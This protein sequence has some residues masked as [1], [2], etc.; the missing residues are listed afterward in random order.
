MTVTTVTSTA[1]LLFRF[2]CLTQGI[3]G[4]RREFCKAGLSWENMS[5]NMPRVPLAR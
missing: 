5:R 1:G 2:I 3:V 4:Y